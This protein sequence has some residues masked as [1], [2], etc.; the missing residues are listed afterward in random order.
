MSRGAATLQVLGTEE[1]ASQKKHIKN[2]SIFASFSPFFFAPVFPH[3]EESRIE[4]DTTTTTTKG[5]TRKSFFFFSFAPKKESLRARARC[6]EFFIFVS[7]FSRAREESYRH[8]AGG[9]G[10]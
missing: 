10:Y 9:K 4:L 5:T 8:H 1:A 2:F 7:V 6:K 3:R